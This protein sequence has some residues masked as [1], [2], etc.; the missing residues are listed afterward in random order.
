MRRQKKFYAWGYADE[1]LSPDEIK[2]WEAE[3]AQRYG[4]NR[5]TV[6]KWRKRAFVTDAPM[7]P[8]EPRSTTLSP[9]QEAIAVAFRRHTLLPLDDCLYAL[10]ATIPTLTRSSLHRLFQRHTIARLPE[11]EGEKTAKKRFKPTAIQVERMNRTLKEA[12]VRAFHYENKEQLQVHLAAFLNAYNFAK[13]LKTLHGLTPYEAVCNAWTETPHR[14]RLP[15]DHLTAGLNTYP[16]TKRRRADD[17]VSTA[18]GSR[19][20]ATHSPG[21]NRPEPVSTHLR[22]AAEEL[23]FRLCPQQLVPPALIECYP[24]PA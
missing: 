24:H 2:P 9:E 19:G 12:T 18:Y 1:D 8:K 4:L 6:M 15:P 23:G 22:L 7:G 20:A 10:Q 11:I 13:R 14:F 3:I 5:K 21:A 16:I 17:A